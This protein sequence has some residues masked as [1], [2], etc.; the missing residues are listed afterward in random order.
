MPAKFIKPADWRRR[1]SDPV[2]GEAYLFYLPDLPITYLSL[3]TGCNIPACTTTY[4]LGTCISTQ[5]EYIRDMFDEFELLS[6]N[7]IWRSAYGSILFSL[8]QECAQAYWSTYSVI[9]TIPMN[10]EHLLDLDDDIWNTC[11]FSVMLCGSSFYIFFNLSEKVLIHLRDNL[12]I[13][14]DN[15]ICHENN[16]FI[17]DFMAVDPELILNEITDPTPGTTALENFLDSL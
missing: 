13:K 14:L 16:T 7:A 10:I 4:N 8:F 5:L 15:L 3:I 2:D 9:P 1:E 6:A 11:S 12:C 17:A